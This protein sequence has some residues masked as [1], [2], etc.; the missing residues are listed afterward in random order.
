MSES[1]LTLP[2]TSTPQ[3]IWLP[4]SS[5]IPLD[6]HRKLRTLLHRCVSQPDNPTHQENLN[7]HL[8]EKGD[9]HLAHPL[10]DPK[11]SGLISQYL[12]NPAN[13]DK[14]KV[15]PVLPAL[16]QINKAFTEIHKAAHPPQGENALQPAFK[17]LESTL[18]SISSSKLFSQHTL[19]KTAMNAIKGA[20][21]LVHKG[22]ETLAMQKHRSPTNDAEAKQ[23][24]KAMKTVAQAREKFA[25]DLEKSLKLGAGIAQQA[26]QIAINFLPGGQVTGVA[27]ALQ[28]STQLLSKA[29]EA[30]QETEKLSQS[31]TPAQAQ[32]H[33]PATNSKS[34]PDQNGKKTPIQTAQELAQVGT[35]IH[36]G[37]KRINEKKPAQ[38]EH[39][40]ELKRMSRT[41]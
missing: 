18:S 2:L 30:I 19:E 34:A 32:T 37:V 39:E 23:I 4:Q 13:Q 17:K 41:L 28:T 21:N 33:T 11:T 20:F 31:K 24:S 38:L 14:T 6:P 25:K 36:S 1:T 15:H 40:S 8:K 10:T 3:K 12:Q 35:Q 22:I 16:D 27:K 9:D 29:G 5:T 7:V 26:G